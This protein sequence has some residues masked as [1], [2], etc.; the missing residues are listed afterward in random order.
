MTAANSTTYQWDAANRLQSVNN[1]SLGSYGYDGNGK[2]VKKTESGTTTYYVYSSF[3]DAAVLEVTSA[4]VQRAY[5]SGGRGKMVALLSP[6]GNFYWIHQDHLGS[7]RKMT[8]SSG[9]VIYRAEFDP[10]GKLLYEW[11]SSNQPHL[12]TKKFTG[13]ERDAGTGLDYAQARYYSADWGR[14]MSPDP[15]GMRAVSKGRPKSLNRYS[16]VEGNPVNFRD[17]R[18]TCLIYWSW[19]DDEH[20]YGSWEVTL[21][22][23]EPDIPQPELPPAV[24]EPVEPP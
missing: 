2:R 7:G 17:P 6:D 8:N 4:G 15:M 5:V 18:G 9:T 12:N 23:D 22:R 16:Y 11:S 24:P 1:G 14:F 10:Y 20:T 13:F 21:C 3:L 19:L